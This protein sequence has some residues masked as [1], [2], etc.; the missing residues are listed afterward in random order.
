MKRTIGAAGI[1]LGLFGCIGPVHA[2]DMPNLKDPQVIGA[3]K[4]LFLEKHCSN[5]HGA[6]GDGGV[7]LNRRDLSD[8]DYVF[9]A[10]AEGRE[11]GGLRM[12]AFRG[13]MSDAEIW[14]AVAYVMS[15]SNKSQ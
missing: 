6:R 9:Q 1:A 8:P 4:T 13:V 15:L 7:N 2:Q 10:I 14:Q 12:P 3:G 5:C 11:K